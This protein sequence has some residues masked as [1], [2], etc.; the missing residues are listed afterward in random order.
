[1]SVLVTPDDLELQRVRERAK[2]NGDNRTLAKIWEREL[3]ELGS[4]A[5]SM[6]ETEALRTRREREDREFR[7]EVGKYVVELLGGQGFRRVR[8]D[9]ETDDEWNERRYFVQAYDAQHRRYDVTLERPE[10]ANLG[11]TY[12]KDC[13]VRVAS[14]IAAELVGARET[15]LRRM[16]GIK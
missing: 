10:K 8:I 14:Q 16:G 6:S 1:V 3:D 7:E 2:R 12:D 5:P 15:Y 4:P 13:L 11:I 9:S